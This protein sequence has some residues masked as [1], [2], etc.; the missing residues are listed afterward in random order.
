MV[1]VRQ[2]LTPTITFSTKPTQTIQIIKKT[3]DLD[4]STYPMRPA[5]KLTT[6]QRNVN[7][8]QTQRTGRLPGKDDRKD[9]T[10]S[11][12]EMLKQLRWKYASCSPSFKL[13]T[14]RL[15]SGAAC[16]RPETIETPKLP[17]ISQIVWQ[18]PSETSTNQCHFNNTNNNSTVYYTQ[19]F[20][21]T[22]L[23]SQ[24]SPP[25][26]TQPQ[27]YVIAREHSP[28]NQTGNE[29]VPFPNCFKTSYR[30]SKFGTACNDYTFWRYNN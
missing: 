14:P 3:E 11:N 5:V 19:K 23:A 12:R 20:S 29:T 7:L 27:N 30:C 15:H 28:R 4:L 2:T 1:V 26:G 16:D 18:Q 22:T 21:K 24:T 13:E 17:P 9:K 8:E 10:K 6:Q 25:K